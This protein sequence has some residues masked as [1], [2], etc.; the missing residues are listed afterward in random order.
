MK[1]IRFL[2]K[3]T[4]IGGSVIFV[5]FLF[6]LMAFAPALSGA[7]QTATP[8]QTEKSYIPNPQLNS[9]ITWSTFHNGWK[10]EEYSNGTG[11]KTL[12]APLSSFYANPISVNPVDIQG[13]LNNYT[14]KIA[15]QTTN[16]QW[17]KITGNYGASGE[18]S[19]STANPPAGG[20][21]E[22]IANST[23]IITFT[24]N[25]SAAA[26]NNYGAGI[27]VDTSSLPS[28]TLQY[29][30]FTGAAE[31]TAGSSIT[32]LNLTEGF[33]SNHGNRTE[34]VLGYTNKVDTPV[35]ISVPLSQ[36]AAD[37]GYTSGGTIYP[38][39]D[40]TLNVPVSTTATTYRV[41]IFDFGITTYAKTLG[42]QI[43]NGTSHSV[44]K[45]SGN[46]Q[47]TSFDPSFKW[48]S[49]ING[50][51][52]VAVSQEMENLT[53]SQTSISDGNYIEQATYQGILTLPTAP[54]L[55]YS[56][57]NITLNMALPGKQYEVAN[58]NGVSYLSIIQ[59]KTNGTFAFGSVNPNTPNSM[60][61]EA[62]YTA[63]QWDSSTHK[64]SFF[65][66]RGLEY[67]WWVGVI[68]GLS[69][70]GL[71]AAAVSHFGGDEENLKIP[72]GKFG[73]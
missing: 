6:I 58:L 72:K 39:F 59:A 28:N 23:G 45:V 51:Y 32:G 54:D 49:I 25:T 29:D 71:G 24:I 13:S 56:N 57:T 12:T 67:Y 33:N 53:E 18:D 63:S 30:Y 38:R 22:T 40:I 27:C 66:L 46:A 50:G 7:G 11:N 21:V 41:Q 16:L 9:N 70:I 4:I 37:I 15:S 14:H 10:T 44:N 8:A 2:S 20:S 36:Y 55:S 43:I 35:Y 61:L 60:I 48:T 42:S 62:K 65:T 26:A 34:A 69:I 73:R 31:I 3:K 64:P 47:L 1:N 5:S 52:S 17:T 19:T 68:G